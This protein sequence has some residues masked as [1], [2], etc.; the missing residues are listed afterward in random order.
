MTNLAQALAD[1]P[2]AYQALAEP[3]RGAPATRRAATPE[4]PAPATPAALDRRADIRAVLASWTAHLTRTRGIPGPRDTLTRLI[5]CH[6]QQ[7]AH[8]LVVAL[9]SETPGPHLRRM[10]HHQDQAHAA[11]KALDRLD[12]ADDIT[13][14][15]Q[16]LTAHLS[17]LTGDETTQLT[18]DLDGLTPAPPPQPTHDGPPHGQAAGPVLAAWLTAH[19]GRTITDGAIRA[20]ATRGNIHR[21]GTQ[22]RWT[23]YDVQSAINHYGAAPPATQV[24]QPGH[25]PKP[26]V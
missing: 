9:G 22:G 15:C 26:T 14:W 12:R 3:R 8:H 10:L 4:P 23:L 1:L 25:H 5:R 11:W 6:R 13:P 18:A 24:D 17:D 7:V 20:A 16:H 19:T 21:A 2:A